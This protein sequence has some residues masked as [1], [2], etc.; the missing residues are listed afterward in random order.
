MPSKMTGSPRKPHRKSCPINVRLPEELA[1]FVEK[2]RIDLS[3]EFPGFEIK[4]SEV[5]RLMICGAKAEMEK[6]GEWLREQVRK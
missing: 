6:R 1:M 4:T 2:A 3:E 5:V